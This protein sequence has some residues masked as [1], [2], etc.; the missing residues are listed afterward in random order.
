MELIP[1]SHIM[2]FRHFFIKNAVPVQKYSA[3]DA[4]YGAVVGG[5]HPIMIAIAV[6]VSVWSGTGFRNQTG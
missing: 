2:A 3:Q 1:G 4:G 6:C 5:D